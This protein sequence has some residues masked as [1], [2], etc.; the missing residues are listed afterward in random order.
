M[1]DRSGELLRA[2]PSP[3]DGY[4]PC[5]GVMLVNHAG[6]VFVGH[7]IGL[8]QDA[9]QMP[10]GGVDEGEAPADAA[11]RELEEEIGTAKARIVAES[12]GW[13]EYDLPPEF[14][15]KR[16]RGK[17]RGQSQK[18]FAC[19]FEGENSDIRLET[20]HP[21]FNDWRWVEIEALSELI[22]TFKREVYRAVVAELAPK[23]RQAIT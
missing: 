22:I 7:R 13:Y 18:W 9:W 5:V 3:S 11:L 21:E 12:A 6:R 14:V 1:S 2:K 23:V 8:T 19:L 20:A 10:Q 16:W 4:R 15:G 17:Y